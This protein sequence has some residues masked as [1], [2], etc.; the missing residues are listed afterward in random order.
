MLVTPHNINNLKTRYDLE[1]L[2]IILLLQLWQNTEIKTIWKTAIYDNLVFIFSFYFF[3]SVSYGLK[4][5]TA[6]HL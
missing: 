5:I 3:I 6:R 4:N 2:I 1:N